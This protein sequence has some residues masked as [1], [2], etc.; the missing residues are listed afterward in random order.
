MTHDISEEILQFELNL[1]HYLAGCNRVQPN[2]LKQ[3]LAY[4]AWQARA[5]VELERR[6]GLLVESMDM[7]T[8]AVVAEGRVNIEHIARLI[9]KQEEGK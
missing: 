3:V 5:H 9:L 7:E 8:L 4:G 1:Y 2:Y 6:M